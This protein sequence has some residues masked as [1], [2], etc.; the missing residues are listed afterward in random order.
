M[1]RETLT[2]E[3]IVLAAIEVLDADGVGG[4]NMRRLGAQLGVAATAMY[5]HVKSKD[6]LVM[7]A[8]DHVWGEIELPELGEIGWRVAVATLARGA[9]AMIS[10]HFW[11]LPAMSTQLIYGPGKARHDECCLAVYEAAGFSDHEADQAAATVLMF[12]IGAAQGE[13]AE[14]AWRAHLRRGGAD[15][16]QYLRET[17]ARISEVAQQFPRLRTRMPSTDTII[18]LP[19]EATFEFGLH[20]ILDGLQARFAHRLGPAGSLHSSSTPPATGPHV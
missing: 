17:I 1:P 9:H 18:A 10:R 5:Y 15:E 16:D 11:L 14:S 3:Q 13:A 12:V 7:L 20:A 4:L 8:A 2:R 19:D 6:E